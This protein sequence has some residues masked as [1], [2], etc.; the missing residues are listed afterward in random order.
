MAAN[1]LSG[2][3][4]V[5][6]CLGIVSSSISAQEPLTQAEWTAR[7]SALLADPV[8]G[9]KSN[10]GI[11]IVSFGGSIWIG[12]P[13]G[14][15]FSP[16]S[17]KT[18]FTH[19][20]GTGLLANN[21]TAMT[22][23]ND[24]LWLATVRPEIFANDTINSGVGLQYTADSLGDL[25]EGP[26]DTTG[27]LDSGTV[28]PLR[29][30]FDIAGSDSMLFTASW[31]GGLIG[32]NDR[33]KS[34]KRFNITAADANFAANPVGAPPV[35]SLYF[36]AVVDTAHFDTAIVWAGHAGGVSR[37]DFVGA[38]IKP[39][40]SRIL[41]F[42]YAPPV[43]PGA[44]NDSGFIFIGG[45][46][47]LTRATPLGYSQWKSVFASDGIG[48][49]TN[50]I[51]QLHYFGG[52]L[53]VGCLDTLD[54][55]GV[56]FVTTTDSLDFFMTVSDGVVDSVYTKVGAKV[57]DFE[58]FDSRYL[59]MAGATAGLFV[60]S[61]TGFSWTHVITDTF[62]GFTTPAW[63]TV[64]AVRADSVG[65]LWCGTDAGLIKLYVNRTD[66]TGAVVDSVAHLP[67]FDELQIDTVG[68]T[69]SGASVRRIM[70]QRFLRPNDTTIVDSTVLW[71]ANSPLSVNGEYSTYRVLP[72]TNPPVVD[73]LF[74]R[75]ARIDQ[76][77]HRSSRA[78]FVGLGGMFEIQTNDTMLIKP[79]PFLS[80][81][82]SSRTPQFSIALNGVRSIL[83]VGDTTHLG[84]ER[85]FAVTTAQKISNRQW[86]ITLSNTVDF[87]PDT[88]A[89]H[90]T[91]NSGL[92]G[93]FVPAMSVQYRVGKAPVIWASTRRGD[94][95]DFVGGI[96]VSYLDMT[97]MTDT[98]NDWVSLP[99]PSELA[100]IRVWNFAFNGD[101]IFAASDSG[102]FSSV[103]PGSP[104]TRLDINSTDVNEPIR[105][106]ATVN[107]VAV[108]G[109]ELWVATDDGFARRLLSDVFF[110]VFK[111]N[112]SV[113]TEAYAYPS[114]FNPSR[115]GIVKFHYRVPDGA[116]SA[117]ISVYDF[118][119]NLVRRVS[120][121]VSRFPGE[122]AHDLVA[123]DKWDG[124]NGN[125]ESV[126]PGIY[127]FKVEF[128]NG[129]NSWG[130]V[131]VIP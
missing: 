124:T 61:D 6:F 96:D 43:N 100:G 126:A 18:W 104:F 80:I 8:L 24:T 85:F 31:V 118:A 130:K 84:T 41:D 74:F 109:D 49:P 50:V 9:Q 79:I 1:T 55:N 99:F 17:G 64:N 39:S 57:L 112:D 93:N 51:N 67:M 20:D 47:G 131:A 105:M 22:T 54:G 83:A 94:I 29:V 121:D 125:G 26:L 81:R 113:T 97:D 110:D 12:T 37:F 115:D 82:D 38:R 90:N 91:A 103:A 128:S 35:T 10:S 21:I 78:Y 5:L 73:L 101:T 107:G 59:Y 77:I 106:G 111:V 72:Y 102:L 30:T 65:D 48:L 60:S 28:G 45:D 122:I 87:A 7:I 62:P 36:S 66:L 116:N 53:F 11:D 98:L 16:D 88:L 89:L 95:T 75:T 19:N 4:V 44:P 117:S 129:D 123:T 108:L 2:L 3:I 58:D 76:M 46:Q 120:T 71:T 114:P 63:A 27:L 13:R 52:L 40:S 15:S 86:H 33:G 68:R 14:V 70:I 25:W 23:I 42:A 69:G 92:G 127:Y 56:G 119:M 34:W 32:S